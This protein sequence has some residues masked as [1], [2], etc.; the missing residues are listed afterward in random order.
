MMNW[1]LE[2]KKWKGEYRILIAGVTGG[3]NELLTQTVLLFLVAATV[4]ALNGVFYS[5]EYGDSYGNYG[6]QLLNPH[7]L[8]LHPPLI[9]CGN[10]HH[11]YS[12]SGFAHP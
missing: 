5:Q 2:G 7:L 10:F 6:Q 3:D 8:Q 11:S 9:L 4:E 12:A 1:I